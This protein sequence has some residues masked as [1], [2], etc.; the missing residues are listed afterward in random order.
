MC[1]VHSSSTLDSRHTDYL[2]RFK[3]EDD[4][5][6]PNLQTEI[7]TA[8]ER[9]RGKL[10]IEAR[11]DLKDAIKTRMRK[12]QQLKRFQQDYFLKNGRHIFGYFEEKKRISEGGT[13]NVKVLHT[14]FNL[15]KPTQVDR[16][17][18]TAHVNQY[19]RQVDPTFVEQDKYVHF[20][21]VCP[22]CRRGELIPIEFEGVVVCNHV[23]CSHQFQHLSEN[24]KPSYKEP[25]Q[26]VCFYAYKRINHFREIIAQFQAKESTHIPQAKYRSAV[27]NNGN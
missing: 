10:S 13:E 19:L 27:G 3:N 26:E 5:V 1:S 4:V 15:E 17:K 21:K 11:L 8:K 25:P 20:S 7:Q 16:Q 23:E 2:R 22:R 24:E 18:M 14:F 12:V 6:I 9:L